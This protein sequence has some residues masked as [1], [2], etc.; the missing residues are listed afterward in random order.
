MLKS[1]FYTFTFACFSLF[2]L[3]LCLSPLPLL[4]MI[5]LVLL[6]P[7]LSVSFLTSLVLSRSL[8]LSLSLLWPLSFSLSAVC[9][10]V[11]LPVRSGLFLQWIFALISYHR[12]TSC[13]LTQTHT[14]KHT[15]ALLGHVPAPCVCLCVLVQRFT[16]FSYMTAMCFSGSAQVHTCCVLHFRQLI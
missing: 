1:L 14:Q 12:S 6:S 11:S 13:L 7:T 16:S 8:L 2:P 9:V 3:Q 4:V 15:R 10:S 5:C